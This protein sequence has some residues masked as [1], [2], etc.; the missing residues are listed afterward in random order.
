MATQPGDVAVDRL[1]TDVQ[2]PGDLSVG[3]ATDGLHEDL[4][5]QVGTFLPVGLG[6]RLGTEGSLTGLAGKPA[7]TVGSDESRVVSGLFERPG[8]TGVL[9]KPAFG[10]GAE[11]RNP[12]FG[13]ELG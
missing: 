8:A 6:E 9:V 10:V 1:G 7:D 12:R 13:I 11:G 5:I 2:V 4:G 3:H